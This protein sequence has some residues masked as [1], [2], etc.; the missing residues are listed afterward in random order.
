VLAESFER[1]HR[2]NL[3]GMGVLPLQFRPGESVR[4][5]GLTGEERVTIRGLAAIT[6]ASW[7]ATLRVEAGDRA[8]DALVCIDTAQEA[9]QYRH[10]GIIPYVLRRRWLGG[11]EHPR[12]ANTASR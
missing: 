5:L 10:G 6:E 2:T 7:P 8:F 4:G 9:A 11:E 3:I 12:W 1:I